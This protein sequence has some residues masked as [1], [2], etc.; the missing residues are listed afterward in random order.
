MNPRIVF[1]L[2]LT[3][4]LISLELYVF[5]GIRSTFKGGWGLKVALGIELVSVIITISGLIGMFIYFS[6]GISSS[7]LFRNLLMGLTITFFITKIVFAFFLLGE[8]IYRIGRLGVDMVSSLFRS[9][10]P[11]VSMESRRKF[12]GQLG[13]VVAA[14]P[15]ASFLYGTLKGKYAYKTHRVTFE[16]PDLPAAFDGLK[17]VQ[18]SDIHAGSFDS[19]EGVK[20]GVDLVQAENPDLILFT[21]DLVNNLAEEIVPYMDLFGGLN[22]KLGKYAILGNH[23][24]GEYYVWEDMAAKR[25]NLIQLQKHHETMGFKMLNNTSITLEKDGQKIRLA[26]VENWG[27]PPFPQK[28]DIDKALQGISPEEFTILMSHDPTH[29][30]EKVLPSAKKVHLTLSGHTHGAQMGV[31]IP[32]FRFSPVQLR[33]RRWAGSYSEKG[34]HLYI[35]RGFGFIGYPGRVGIWPEVTVIELKRA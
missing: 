4:I 7:N 24:Y 11:E 15:F 25:Q 31:E 1:L 34:Q 17:I 10:G 12:I 27:L 16:F 3:L 22:A 20:R 30:D 29:W 18:L 8:D 32:G 13:L 5:R 35:N 33:Y 2:V 26:G 14:I 28:G 9:N 21:G 19:L 23:D 6:G